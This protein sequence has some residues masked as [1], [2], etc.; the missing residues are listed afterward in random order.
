[1]LDAN[2]AARDAYNRQQMENQIAMKRQY[3]DEAKQI[4]DEKAMRKNMEKANELMS[5]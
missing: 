1:M 4:I 2:M 5:D 3:G